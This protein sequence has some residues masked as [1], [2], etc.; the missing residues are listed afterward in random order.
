MLNMS[1]V[2]KC[3]EKMGIFQFMRVFISVGELPG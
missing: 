3:S 2:H 1:F